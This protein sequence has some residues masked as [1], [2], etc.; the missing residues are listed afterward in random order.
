MLRA[1]IKEGMDPDMPVWVE[2]HKK[3][4][5]SSA[6]ENGRENIVNILITEYKVNIDL[7]DE[8]GCT[9]L[10]IAARNGWLSVVRTLIER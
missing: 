1:L 10:M 7:P 3:T 8:S 9:P 6:C 2:N 5:L 4:L